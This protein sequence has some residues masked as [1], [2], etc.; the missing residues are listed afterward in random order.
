MTSPANTARDKNHRFPGDIIRHGVWRYYRFILSDRDVQE[1]LRERGIDVTYEVIRHWCRT[2]GQDSANLLRRQRPQSGDTWHLA[3][4]FLRT[5]GQRYYLW[6][7]VDQD[8]NVLDILVQSR[9]NK[10]AAKKVS[11]K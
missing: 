7:A 3:A 9:R 4:V 6:R 8:D 11:F 2:F 10:Q 1:L 5:N